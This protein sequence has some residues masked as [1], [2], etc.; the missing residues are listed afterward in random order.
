M[1][2]TPARSSAALFW[3]KA[4]TTS[5]YSGSL[6]SPLEHGIK[7]VRGHPAGERVLL[8]GVVTANKH[9]RALRVTRP[10]GI[11]RVIRIPRIPRVTRITRVTRRRACGLLS[12]AREPG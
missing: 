6:A 5:G 7:H 12:V 1:P 8:A 2:G 4:H 9:Y 3:A 11:P 10:P